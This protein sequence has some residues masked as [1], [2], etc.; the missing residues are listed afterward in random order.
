MSKLKPAVPNTPVRT[1][2]VC[3]LMTVYSC[4]T[5]YNWYSTEQF[6]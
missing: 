3:V 5:Q 2:H 4:G 6:W 1:A